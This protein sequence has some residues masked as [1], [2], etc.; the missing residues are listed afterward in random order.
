M[1]V[2]FV[3]LNA[4]LLVVLASISNSLTTHCLARVNVAEGGLKIF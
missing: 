2:S 3:E 4:S 1:R